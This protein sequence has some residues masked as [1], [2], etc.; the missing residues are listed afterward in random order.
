MGYLL[1]INVLLALTIS[2]KKNKKNLKHQCKKQNVIGK[3]LKLKAS[4]KET[5][6]PN[7]NH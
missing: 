1:N 3:I 6:C 7:S 4:V 5:G 2:K